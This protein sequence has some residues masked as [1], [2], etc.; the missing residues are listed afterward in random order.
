MQEP[1]KFAARI[2]VSEAGAADILGQK[3]ITKKNKNSVHLDINIQSSMV[4]TVLQIVNHYLMHVGGV[5]ARRQE[6]RRRGYYPICIYFPKFK[7]ETPLK[8][9]YT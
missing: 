1:D 2:G 6:Q 4:K 9:Y 8:I 5:S 7:K 3:N